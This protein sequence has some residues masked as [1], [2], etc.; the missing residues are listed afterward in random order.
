MQASA[1][2]HENAFSS[3]FI[4]FVFYQT[5]IKLQNKAKKVKNPFSWRSKKLIKDLILLKS[6]LTLIKRHIAKS[7]SLK[8]VMHKD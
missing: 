6:Q 4:R 5:K 2:M 7:N 8:I 1:V 3:P